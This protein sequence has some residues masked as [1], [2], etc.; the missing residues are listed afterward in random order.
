MILPVLIFQILEMPKAVL[1]LILV[2]YSVIYSAEDES[3]AEQVVAATYLWML[4]YHLKILSS[5][6]TRM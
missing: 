6:L 1:N 4:K 3:V 2:I 5:V